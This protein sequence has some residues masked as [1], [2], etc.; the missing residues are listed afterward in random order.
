ME[1]IGRRA[2]RTR[3]ERA[4]GDPLMGL[5]PD[6]PSPI[7]EPESILGQLE[8][9]GALVLG[10]LLEG[11]DRAGLAEAF[12]PGPRYGGQIKPLLDHLARLHL[13]GERVVMVSRQAARLAEL[14]HE[15]GIAR[16][17]VE[18]LVEAPA[19]VEIE[20]LPRA[21]SVLIPGPARGA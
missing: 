6:Y 15:R 5:P 8:E 2:E 14:W 21:L 1:E 11:S 13:N 12:Q 9:Q 16:A 19:D 7:A 3:A 10:G 20:V 18:E 17:P 4:S